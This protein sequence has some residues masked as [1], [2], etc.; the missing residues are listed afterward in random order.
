MP[1]HRTARSTVL[2]PLLPLVAAL[3]VWTPLRH[4]FFWSDD[5]VHLYD[6][7]TRSL[8]SFSSELFLGQLY[9][10]RDLVFAGLFHAFGPDPRPY[11]WSVLLTHAVNVLLL[12]RAIRAFAGDVVLSA[13][14]AVLWGTC[15]VLEGALGWYSAYGRVLLTTLVLVVIADLGVAVAGRETLRPRRALVLGRPARRRRGL[16]HRRARG[17]RR[18][19]AHRAPRADRPTAER[20]QRRHPRRDRAG[21]RRALPPPARALIRRRP[22]V[23]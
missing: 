10:V 16:L 22:S 5:F 13:V 9:L 7:A 2:A 6:I 14:G 11:F 8:W 18:V 15:P 12:E 20:A 21:D 3:A 1:A 19:P 4:N 23:S 17:L